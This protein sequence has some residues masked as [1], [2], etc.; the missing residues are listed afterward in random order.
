MKLKKGFVYTP[1]S[2]LHKQIKYLGIAAHQDDIEIMAFDG[3]SK[4]YRSK[5]F[6]FA[7]VVTCDGAGSARTGKFKDYTDD[8]MKEIRIVEQQKAA[9]IGRYEQLYLL[10]YSSKE[11]KDPHNDALVEEYFKIIQEIKPDVI[12]THNI[13]D[14]HPTHLGVVLKVIKALRMLPKENRP[15][16]VYGCEVWRDLDWVN[17]ESKVEFDVSRN[18]KLAKDILNVFESQII[19]GKRYDLAT[20]GRRYSNATYCASHS[21]DSCKMVS[22][23]IDLTPLMKDSNLDVKQ[24]ALNLISDFAKNVSEGLDKLM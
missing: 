16:V 10:N 3:I 23:A 15:K 18:H 14:K 11:V 22:Y 8:M 4:G 6:S 21:V 19:G 5:K 7:A 13:L 1:S 2:A 20:I 17:D 12:Y 9:E 24:F